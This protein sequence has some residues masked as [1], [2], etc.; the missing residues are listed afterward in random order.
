[1]DIR[2]YTVPDRWGGECTWMG[3]TWIPTNYMVF[4]GLIAYGHAE[5]ARALAEKTFEEAK[6]DGLL[7][8][9]GRDFENGLWLP[10]AQ[11]IV[12]PAGCRQ[13]GGELAFRLPSRRPLR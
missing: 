4:R 9:R 5:V 7:L 11:F 3:A 8:V 13:R 1:M 10:S 2:D 6:E 12:E